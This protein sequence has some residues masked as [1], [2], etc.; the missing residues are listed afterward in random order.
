MN[1]TAS[2]YIKILFYLLKKSTVPLVSPPELPPFYR[3]CR[4]VTGMKQNHGPSFAVCTLCTTDNSKMLR[5]LCF[6]SCLLIAASIFP[7]EIMKEDSPELQALQQR[8]ELDI[9]ENGDAVIWDN[10][11]THL[12]TIVT[13]LNTWKAASSDASVDPA[14]VPG[15]VPLTGDCLNL[16]CDYFYYFLTC[17][18][19][20]IH[21]DK[22]CASYFVGMY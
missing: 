5:I 8:I 18:Q 1:S 15:T 21:M 13:A 19:F 7:E 22:I 4:S 14:G 17:K 16:E 11:E 6:L 20:G 2:C 12:D 10:M 9:A 3:I